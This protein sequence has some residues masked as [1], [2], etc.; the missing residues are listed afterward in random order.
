MD[1]SALIRL[2]IP[3]GPV[4][5]EA[6][7]ALQAASSGEKAVL[8]PGLLLVE[9]SSVLLRKER[10]G[11]LSAAEVDELLTCI[12]AL[13]IRL[14]DRPDL[15]APAVLLARTYHLSAYDAL[16]LA[17]AEYHQARLLTCDRELAKVASRLGIGT[18]EQ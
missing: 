14:V 12:I 8:A 4:L 2:L 11:E 1:T 16:Y 9:A 7:I 15:V 3:D 10:R 18:D 5:A 17:L 13:P 6:E